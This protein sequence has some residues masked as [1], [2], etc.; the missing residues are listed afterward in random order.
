MSSQYGIDKIVEN[1]QKL[2]SPFDRRA[3]LKCPK[4]MKLK[5]RP[6]IDMIQ[7]IALME[8]FAVDRKSGL[9]HHFLMKSLYIGGALERAHLFCHFSIERIRSIRKLKFLMVNGKIF[10]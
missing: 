2:V 4:G 9:V 8:S 10:T 1:F 7:R 3:D 5:R 6:L